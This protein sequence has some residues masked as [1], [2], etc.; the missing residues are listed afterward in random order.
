MGRSLYENQCLFLDVAITYS[1]CVRLLSKVVP[2]VSFEGKQMK[3][4]RS[5]IGDTCSRSAEVFDALV[6]QIV[7]GRIDIKRWE[8]N[9]F[10]VFC[11]VCKIVMHIK[12]DLS[13]D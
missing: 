4:Y 6:M 3:T 12:V 5:R 9:G 7:H 10:L 2:V 13:K 8:W 11:Y 1:V